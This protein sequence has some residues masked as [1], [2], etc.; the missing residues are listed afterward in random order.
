MHNKASSN[1]DCIV[2]IS[3]LHIATLT[4]LRQLIA[5]IPS[6]GVR[7]IIREVDVGVITQRLPIK[8]C[9][10]IIKI[11][12]RRLSCRMSWISV[13]KLPLIDHSPISVIGV[14]QIPKAGAIALRI[15]Q[16]DQLTDKEP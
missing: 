8:T 5:R 2:A 4:N 12:R 7:P 16:P 10:P 3:K 13:P 6:V 14:R 9:L 11:N 15:G 1:T